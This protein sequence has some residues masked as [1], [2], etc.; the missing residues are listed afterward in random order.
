MTLGE[1]IDLFVIR[2]VDLMDLIRRL[3]WSL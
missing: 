3:L 2:A 1:L